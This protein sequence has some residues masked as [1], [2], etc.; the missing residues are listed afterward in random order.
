MIRFTVFAA[1]VALATTFSSIAAKADFN[2]GPERN[3]NQ[4]WTRHT[5]NGWTNSGFG[6]WAECPKPASA[7][8][9]A[10]RK[11]HHTRQ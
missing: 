1:A 7:P 11:P 6:Y 8:A 9:P 5:T 4:C 3:G 2:F 10:V